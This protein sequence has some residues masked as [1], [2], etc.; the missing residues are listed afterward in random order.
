MVSPYKII[1][2]HKKFMRT[3]IKTRLS[4]PELPILLYSNYLGRHTSYDTI[5]RNVFCDN[6]IWSY[7]DIASNTQ[8]SE[9]LRP[10]SK[11]R[12][13]SYRATCL[14]GTFVSYQ[15]TTIKHTIITHFI[16]IEQHTST[17]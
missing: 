15:H 10:W 8:F 16:H 6:S 11:F 17:T 2:V 9:S 1:A 4:N 3:A 13:I 14:L 12:I 5:I 7:I